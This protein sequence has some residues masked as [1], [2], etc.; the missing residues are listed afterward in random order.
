MSLKNF[1]KYLFYK[2]HS[3]RLGYLY[4]K[5]R[6]I[7]KT[8]PAEIIVDHPLAARI[9]VLAPHCDDETIG[10]GGAIYKHSSAGGYVEV[11]FMTRDTSNAIEETRMK[12]AKAAAKVL[13]IKKC[14]FLKNKDGALSSNVQTKNDL[15]TVLESVNP[16][17]VYLPF[18][19]DNHPDHIETVKIFSLVCKNYSGKFSCYCYEVWTPLIPNKLVDISQVIEKKIEALQAYKSQLT[20]NNLVEKIRGL[21][22]YRSMPAFPRVEYMEAFYA[23]SETDLIKIVKNIL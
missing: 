8:Q 12:E 19:F 13:G 20:E 3:K 1:T 16:Q 9:L 15:L 7:F 11:V 2:I 17:I 21:N 4:Q 10:C 6:N 22:R 23:C 5:L 14:T 18:F